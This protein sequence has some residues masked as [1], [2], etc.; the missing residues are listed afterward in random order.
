MSAHGPVSTVRGTHRHVRNL[1]ISG[2]VADIT[3]TTLMTHDG[4][5]F[6]QHLPESRDARL[7]FGLRARF[8]GPQLI[9]INA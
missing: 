6:A 3:E 2:F 4:F 7:E 5:P 1:R 8:G 9:Y